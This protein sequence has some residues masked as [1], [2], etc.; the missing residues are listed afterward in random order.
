[1]ANVEVVA[2]VNV[3]SKR[4]GLTGPPPTPQRQPLIAVTVGPTPAE[5]ANAGAATPT[6]TRGTLQAAPRATERRETCV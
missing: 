1:M 6:A 3:T 2:L 4:Y 5:A